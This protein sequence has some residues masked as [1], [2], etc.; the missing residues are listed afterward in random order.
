MSREIFSNF[1]KSGIVYQ[2]T[3]SGTLEMEW[4]REKIVI[5]LRLLDLSCLLCMS[6]RPLGLK[7]FFLPLDEQVT[8]LCPCF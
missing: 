1:S 6:L 4:Q 2:T 8:F 5:F 3:Y 7:L